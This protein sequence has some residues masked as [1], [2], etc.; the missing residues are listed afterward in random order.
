MRQTITLYIDG[1]RADCD[2]ATLVQMTYTREELDNPTIV[3]NSYSQ[4]VSLPSTP[5]N[6]RIFS[7]YFRNDYRRDTGFNP[8][9]RLPFVL[10]SDTGEVL[11]QGY[12]KLNSV[13]YTGRMAHSYSCTL[14]GGLGGFFYGLTYKADGS[15]KTLADL[16]YRMTEGGTEIDL[17]AQFPMSAAFVKHAWDDLKDGENNEFQFMNFAPANNGLPACKFSADKGIYKPGAVA[18]GQIPNLYT[19]QDGYGPK[20]G[21]DGYIL[22]EMENEHT[23]WETQE[24]RAYLQRPVLRM[25]YLLESLKW[26]VNTSG[27]NFV[28]D[29]Y[30]LFDEEYWY[31]D[32]LWM[33]LPMFDRD[34]LDPVGCTMR[35]LLKNTATP[36]DYLIG[37]AKMFG[38]VFNYDPVT[39]TI[40]MQCRDRF[41]DTGLP[42]IDLTHRVD[43][44]RAQTVAPFPFTNK[45]ADFS[46]AEQ[47]EFVK[48]YAEKYG[49][50][51]GSMR[52]DTGF[53]FDATAKN[54]LDGIVYKGAADAVESNRNYCVFGGATNP[55][56]GSSINYNLKFAFSESVSWRL[57][58]TENNETTEQE[59]APTPEPIRIFAYNPD[60]SDF[61]A[62]PQFH[63]ADNKATDGANVL[64]FFE[65]WVDTPANVQGGISIDEA[66]FRLTDDK[67]AME[68]LNAGVPCWDFTPGNGQLVQSLP[69]FRRWERTLGSNVGDMLDFGIA[70]EYITPEV[71]GQYAATMFENWWRAYLSDRYDP[72]ARVL[73]C[74]VNLRGLGSLP[75]L[76]RRFFFYDGS[77]WSLNKISN[78][79]LTTLDPTECEFIR[80][81]DMTNYTSGQK[82]I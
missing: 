13:A 82:Y 71:P 4:N 18:S 9:V 7:C 42:V 44:G 11:E 20:S 2:T 26:A 60:Y 63:D 57:Y 32:G 77:I 5:A 25:R 39:K 76:L 53:E 72:D 70:R 22:V 48:T 68:S 62:R 1:N 23:E 81:Q 15:K 67:A 55:Q 36:A 41:Y 30:Q 78:H 74:F 14:Y 21:A 49:R 59:C 31:Y 17:D 45:Y 43:G 61:M 37:F 66:N 34:K 24:L 69:T 50:D 29:T 3:R 51:Y 38:C 46:L 79:S 58:K 33:T 65:G 40:T 35:D 54:L 19:S 10:H 16:R 80:V 75:E 6:D 64:L 47:G 28:L 56:Y 8:L 27:Y 12:L 73:K 52:L